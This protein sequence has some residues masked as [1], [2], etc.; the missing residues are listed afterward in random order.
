MEIL[1]LLLA[2]TGAEP[3]G[4]V[5]IGTVK[6]DIHDI[7][8]NLVAMMLEGAGARG[9]R[10]RHQQRRRLGTSPLEKE[11]LDISTSALL[12]TTMP[13]MKVVVDTLEG[14]GDARRLHR[15]GRWRSAERGVRGGG[16]RRLPPRT[17]RWCRDARRPGRAPPP[18]LPSRPACLS[19]HDRPRAPAGGAGRATRWSSSC[20]GT[21]RRRSTRAGS[22]A[23]SCCRRS[24][25]GPS[26]GAKRKAGIYTAHD[27][28]SYGSG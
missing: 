13:Y 24:S 2:E 27:D 17:P 7:G 25:S 3:V 20:G 26:T 15:A 5:V 28:I 22:G 18:G 16:G 14:K 10:H 1:R 12:T 19:G 4:K 11:K 9:G 23:R 8:K 6:G 21:S